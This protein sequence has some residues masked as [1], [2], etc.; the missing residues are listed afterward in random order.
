MGSSAAAARPAE[1]EHGVTVLDPESTWIDKFKALKPQNTAVQG[2]QQLADTIEALINKVEPNLPGATVQSGIFQW[3]K[4]AFIAQALSLTP[5]P[6]QT[7]IPILAGAWTAGCSAAVI[8]PGLV[9]DATLWAVST[10][11]TLT[12][13]SAAATIPTISAGSSILQALLQAVPASIASTPEKA[14]ENMAKAFRAA[15]LAF[16]FTLIGIAGTPISPV[17]T[18]V[19]APAQ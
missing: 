16:V 14:P 19:P 13:P 3:N 11:D 9:T 1:I 10:S 6:G 5:S 17:P 7:W 12:L 4:A 8:T 15:T 2:I 18:P